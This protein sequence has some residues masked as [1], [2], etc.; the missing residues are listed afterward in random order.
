[1]ETP[2]LIRLHGSAD[3]LVYTV[4]QQDSVD[5]ETVFGPLESADLTALSSGKSVQVLVPSTEVL[6]TRV[7]LPKTNAS[8]LAKAIPYA[9]E[10]DVAD[11]VEAL[12]FA[13]ALQGDGIAVAVVARSTLD[14][15]L[16]CLRSAGIEPDAL[17]P[18]V[19]AVPWL[20]NTWSL[21]ADERLALVRTGGRSGF[22]IELGALQGCLDAALLEAKEQPPAQ[23]YLYNIAENEVEE[24]ITQGFSTPAPPVTS[25]RI[26]DGELTKLLAYKHL[27]AGLNLLQGAYTP[28]GE[29]KNRWMVWR[30]SAA[31]GLLLLI[32]LGV[33]ETNERLRLRAATQEADAR[34]EVLFR[35]TF[36]E[37]QRIINPVA[38]MEQQLHALRM[39]HNGARGDFLAL[40]AE[41][42]ASLNMLAGVQVESLDYQSGRLDLDVIVQDVQAL[43][44]LKRTLR[45]Q[46]KLTIEIISA[47]AAD[48]AV[49]SRIRIE[50]SSS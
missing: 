13:F 33:N 12:H 8:R 44:E 50:R 37:T 38:Q 15:W 1:M 7:Q 11:D 24:L 28:R 43:D 17:I 48:D 40:L 35:K 16:Q 9:L 47:T 29:A 19:L 45:A 49:R 21:V 26:E 18:D 4:I 39:R 25:Q 41:G 23:L 10:E 3:E 32:A 34:L 2:L 5:Q 22:S 46:P 31:L 27:P 30:L 14:A 36:P 20:P 42:G 6:L